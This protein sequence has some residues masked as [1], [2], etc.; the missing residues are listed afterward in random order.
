MVRRGLLIGGTV[1][2]LGAAAAAVVAFAMRDGREPITVGVIHSLT[3][4]LAINEKPLLDAYALA[5]QRINE[6]GGVLGRPVRLEV[7]DGASDPA[8]FAQEA[9]R[10]LRDPKVAVLAG[11]WSSASRKAMEEALG[12]RNG[13]LLYPAPFEGL[14]RSDHIA[15]L[16]LTSNQVLGPSIDWAMQR[17][18]KTFFLVGG[19]TLS[20]RM[21]NAIARDIVQAR[22][23]RVV[24]ERFM[25]LSGGDPQALA[26]AVAEAKPDAVINTV[27]GD[28][29][30]GLMRAMASSALDRRST[31]IISLAVSEPAIRALGVEPFVDTLLVGSYFR[32]I[33]SAANQQFQR[34]MQSVAGS[35]A[36]I[37]DAMAS[38][39][40]GL[41]LWA[42]AA[43]E[44]GQLDPAAVH[45]SLRGQH[46]EGPAGAVVID[47]ATHYSWKPVRL[48]R[49]RADG[50]IEL[51]WDSLRPMAPVAWPMWRN[52]TEWARLVNA[53]SSGRKD[54]TP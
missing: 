44:A 26:T 7:R 24:G 53:A 2:A 20:S 19:E 29:C 35:D 33:D 12:R 31:M 5:V 42:R 32:S 37:S 21:Q 25:P 28:A 13:L 11:G 15:Y 9:E 50:E 38:A 8:A 18:A 47:P 51:V 23:A 17:G 34:A 43:E 54:A 22:G 27:P 40:T 48:G 46:A 10:L 14:E 49:V 41:L 6:S 4:P 30:G 36:P 52:E 1:L 45:R 3:G 39:Y 16:G